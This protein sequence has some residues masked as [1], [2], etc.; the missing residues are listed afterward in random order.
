MTGTLINGPI[1]D[2]TILLCTVL[3][4]TA[5]VVPVEKFIKKRANKC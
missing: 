4:M 2:I 1:L 3:G 5:I